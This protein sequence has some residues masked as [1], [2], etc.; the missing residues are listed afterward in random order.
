MIDNK[1]TASGVATTE[2][3]S[4]NDIT[5]DTMDYTKKE[6]KF[7]GNVV[8]R[9]LLKGRENAIPGRDLTEMIG[10]GSK[11]YLQSLISIERQNGAMILSCQAGYFL[12]DDGEKGREEIQRF[13]SQ[14]RAMALNTLKILKTAKHALAIAEGQ[15]ELSAWQNDQE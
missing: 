1:K 5:T 11:R 14:F 3:G 4:G 2:S 6:A 7:Q 8:E 9:Y 12:P 10:C 13:I 15:M